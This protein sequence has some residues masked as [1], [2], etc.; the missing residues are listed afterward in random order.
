MWIV[1]IDTVYVTKCCPQCSI[2]PLISLM[3]SDAVHGSERC[4][5]N[6]TP[7]GVSRVLGADST[8]ATVSNWEAMDNMNIMCRWV[9]NQINPWPDDLH[10]ITVIYWAW[11]RRICMEHL[12]KI[13]NYSACGLEVAQEQ[14]ALPSVNSV[15]TH[16]HTHKREN[17]SPVAPSCC[18]SS[19]TDRFSE[20]ISHTDV[21]LDSSVR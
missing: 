4:T 18:R 9:I 19:L 21:V 12:L 6:S 3:N 13:I 17:H 2:S 5:I 16:T 10:R 15:H 20:Q 8:R 11:Q 14:S 7:P 1:I